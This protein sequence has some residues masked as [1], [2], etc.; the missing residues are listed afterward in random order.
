MIQH[1]QV[2]ISWIQ[3]HLTSN[4]GD[5][6]QQSINIK[7]SFHKNDFTEKS[8]ELYNHTGI[9]QVQNNV[10]HNK[11]YLIQRDINLLK[12]KIDII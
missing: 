3:Q 4:I 11:D 8:K 7:V 12:K 2:H 9:E 10:G 6:R 5:Y 1:L